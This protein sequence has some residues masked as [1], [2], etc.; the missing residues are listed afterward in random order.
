[1]MTRPTT[2]TSMALQC[3]VWRNK[4]NQVPDGRP[5]L[6][7]ILL[8]TIVFFLSTPA[9]LPAARLPAARL[10]SDRQAGL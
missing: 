10:A 2:H 3:T 8:L 6:N 7:L 1:M 5:Y 4:K 9:R